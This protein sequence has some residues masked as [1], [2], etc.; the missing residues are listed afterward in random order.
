MID[1]LLRMKKILIVCLLAS[2]FPFLEVA[3]QSFLDKRVDELINSMTT[4]EKLEQMY[5]NRTSFGGTP[6][7]LRLGIPG[8]VMGD[9][10]HGVRLTSDRFDRSATAFPTGIAMTA[11][12][13]E[14]ILE[15]VGG[16]M[17]LE[18]WSFNRQQALGPC[19][20]LARDS[21]GGRTAESG[22][23]DPYLAGHLAKSFT[24]GMQ[25]YPIIATLKHFMGE[26]MQSNRLKMDVIASQ[27]WLMDFSGYNFRIP[28][29]DAGAMSV[30]DSYNKINGDKAAESSILLKTILRERWGFPFYVVSDWANIDEARNAVRAGTD[31][32][33][34]ASNYEADLP[35]L[36]ENGHI[37]MSQID[38]AVRNILKT[39]ILNG[40]LDYYPAGNESN[41]KTPEIADLNLLTAQK[42]IILIKNENSGANPILPL[43]KTG[44]KIAL[45]GPNATAENLNCYGSS[46]T[47]PPY[48]ISVKKGLEDKIG[49]ANISY[50]KGCDINSTSKAGFEE[51]K[52]LAATADYVIFA[53]G[54]DATQEGEG[55]G[56][57]NDRTGGSFAL[58]AIQ[59]Q[60]VNELAAVN[61]NLIAIIQSGGVCTFNDCL[62]NIK[63]FVYSFY[64]AQEAGRA[65]ADVVFGDYNPAGRM[66][67][68]M[69][70]KDTDFP[71]WEEDVFRKFEQ[72]LDGGYRWLD[73]NGISPRYA[74]GYGLSYTT[75]SYSNLQMPSEI[76]VGQPFSISVDVKNTG[77]RAGEEVVQL[78][79]TA[80]REKVW[81]PKK[82]LRGFR[83]ISLAA[84]ETKTVTF[85][86]CADDFYYWSQTS[87]KYDVQTGNYIFR[88]G[89]ASD[90]LPLSQQITFKSG[91]G[92]P[93]LRITRVYTMPRYP[94]EGQK[95]SFYALV[96]NQGNAATT[97]TT[98][99]AISFSVGGKNVA[100]TAE[101]KTVI[102]P[103]QVQLIASEGEWVSKPVGKASLGAQLAFSNTSVEW[104]SD[105]NSYVGD[106]EVFDS[107]VVSAQYK[108]LAYLKDVTVS[109]EAGK[110]F[111]NQL[112][113]GDLSTRW[114]SENGAAESAVVDLAAI[115][116][117]DKVQLFWDTDYA[118]Q[119]VLERS[120]D[121]MNWIELKSATNSVGG[122]EY[123]N[124][125][126][127]N[128][129]YLRI[130]FIER[131][132]GSNKFSLREIQVL[133]SEKEKMP[134]AKVI[135]GEKTVLLP[136]AKTYVD[137]TASENSMTGK[138]TYQ[139]TQISGPEQAL[140]ASPALSLTELEF[141]TV[142]TYLMRLLVSNGVNTA[143]KDFSVA[144][145]NPS[146][147]N[148][149]AFKKP[150]SASSSEKVNMYP[151]AAVD[152]SDNTRWSS[153]HKNGEW[154]QVDLQHQVKPSQ[155]SILWHNEYAKKFNIQIS[156]DGNTWN[157][158]ATNDSFAGGTSKSDNDGNVSGRYVRVNCV[159]R[160]GQWENS[161]KTFNLYGD[162]VT[163]TNHLPTAKARC[164]KQDSRYFLDAQE[165]ADVDGDKL[166]YV[167][168]QLTGP[169]FVGIE[170]P[171]TS[172]ASLS[173]LQP[174]SY[175][176]KVTVDDGKDIDF[177][178]VHVD[179]EEIASSITPIA[180][181]RSSDRLQ[182]FPNPA[183][184]HIFIRINDATNA[185]IKIL[186][187]NGREIIR[188][189]YTENSP[190]NLI[191]NGP[192]KSGVYFVK[193][194][195]Q[196]G[197]MVKKI[198]VN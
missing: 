97:S 37:T 39:K 67:L 41:A 182:V 152:G 139:W 5:N 187:M 110:Y 86:L 10:P 94:I 101:T 78:Y 57:G 159:E 79:M 164:Y 193:A 166:T 33:M 196:T 28:I 184:D 114:D 50:A 32:C 188:Q 115:C 103:G 69:P 81:M 9:S 47:N 49:A 77:S 130:R 119:Y 175:F 116:E 151:Q 140:I 121:G 59:Q 109:S 158:Y 4:Q 183:R 186:D 25:R 88:V 99:Y 160:S 108:N 51:A 52:A 84:G 36:V 75:F 89:G 135:L 70:M 134:S 170:N 92:K 180:L 137:A 117:A 76:S 62:P 1:K 2:C 189:N 190:V 44:V 48:A 185:S 71:A 192:L 149:L 20:D 55:Y 132:S 31:I 87:R 141:K 43:R 136:H 171:N 12:W 54:L 181:N 129:R 64:A 13:D 42:S 16:Y 173:G 18:F 131:K 91:T 179:V 143:F 65:I 123:H 194:I 174:G 3:A 162:F 61:P 197:V 29:Q 113:D 56:D 128:L 120:M 125:E 144:V 138:L 167:W 150:T 85:H 72:N 165:S 7:N 177:K 133:G 24:I 23:E 106:M 154:W 157:T 195:E 17:G 168:S 74:F 111:G 45:I 161:I 169:A 14:S 145:V 126:K 105:N 198:I 96:K 63:G 73:E 66:P 90:N 27:R 58:P 122:A 112:V 53:G 102:A 38:N 83:R 35:A 93:D 46:A 146:E 104:D 191:A 8:F 40:M 68:S 19:L 11:T 60:L 80:P 30:M 147:A 124:F 156:P 22:G 163:N 148:D 98:P 118:K 21:R 178:I 176:F 100:A 6:A 172:L 107:S 95:V 155:I 34:G 127:F 82:E 142:G 15:K 153:A 26:S